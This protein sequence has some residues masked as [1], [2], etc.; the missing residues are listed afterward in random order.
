MGMQPPGGCGAGNPSMLQWVT[1]N[2]GTA[3][4]ELLKSFWGVSGG[5]VPLAC[6]KE[7]QDEQSW[8][9]HPAQL[10]WPP[11]ERLGNCPAAAGSQGSEE[12][13]GG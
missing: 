9:M 5:S 12:G 4:E 11:W 6:L 13:E 8:E 2:A 10:T 7:L 3:G 1:G